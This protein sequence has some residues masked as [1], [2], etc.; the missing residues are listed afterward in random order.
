MGPGPS[1][2]HPSVLQAAGQPVVGH[3]DHYFSQMM[4]EIKSLLRYTFQTENLV[5]F[6]ISA[7]GT[8]GMESSF[9]NLVE[10]GDKI[11]VCKNGAF[12]GRMEN[13]ANRMGAA[14][15]LVED[16]WGC[17]VNTE[18]LRQTIT[19]HPDAKLVAFVHAET[20]TGALS[21]AKS[22]CHLAKQASMLTIVDA[23]TSLA[24]I[25]V[26]TDSWGADIVYSGSQKCL[27]SLPGLSP[28]TFS[29]KA[30]DI[31][32][33]RKTKVQSWFMDLNLLLS[34]WEKSDS[35]ARSYHHTAPVNSLYALCQSL[36]IVKRKTLP[37]L[38]Q[39]HMQL[40]LILAEGLQDL[41]F[42]FLCKENERLP[43]LN[44]VFPPE[45]K[46]ASDI[47]RIAMEDYNLELGAGLGELAGK[48]IRI[49]LMGH[50]ASLKKCFLLPNRSQKHFVLI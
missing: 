49:G 35:G 50:S 43:Q 27:S 32:K 24:G 19:K 9:A 39:K 14:V 2:I 37:H 26:E 30:I 12:G 38:H 48:A 18:K 7:P 6:P 42:R 44:T 29:Q 4:D 5:T 22:I 21:D 3:L 8:V 20:S 25:P 33:N 31:I 34:Y 13:M 16:P 23:V 11:I 15:V 10:E 36:K 17:P 1:A 40:H 41:G 28:I 47:I 46:T 45:G